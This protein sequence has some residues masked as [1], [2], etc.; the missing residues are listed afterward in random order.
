MDAAFYKVCDFK[1]TINFWI[2]EEVL[3]DQLSVIYFRKDKFLDF[4]K[5]RRR[6]NLFQHAIQT[7]VYYE[8]LPKIVNRVFASRLDSECIYRHLSQ[9]HRAFVPDVVEV[10]I[11]NLSDFFQF[12]FTLYLLIF[13]AWIVHKLIRFFLPNALWDQLAQS[14]RQFLKLISKPKQT[15]LVCTLCSKWIHAQSEQSKSNSKLEFE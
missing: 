13:C 5:N 14:W 2:S 10:K 3:Y 6:F 8:L 1:K 15:T 11:D 9:V 7:G 12:L 4:A